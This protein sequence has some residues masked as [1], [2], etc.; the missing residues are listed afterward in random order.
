MEQARMM[1]CGICN[2]K[3]EISEMKYHKSG[4]YL[5]CTACH[6]KQSPGRKMVVEK[7]SSSSKGVGKIGYMC[8]NC[9]YSFSRARDH[10]FDVCPYCGKNTVSLVDNGG[11]QNFID[12]S[13]F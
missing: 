7:P 10:K 13:L 2:I 8:K 6:E 5:L 11:A 4:E 1:R 12:E 3:S 9:S